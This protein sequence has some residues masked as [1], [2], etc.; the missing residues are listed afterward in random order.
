MVWVVLD[1]C[2]LIDFMGLCISFV[3]MVEIYLV[4]SS[5]LVREVLKVLLVRDYQIFGYVGLV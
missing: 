3:E 5:C 1:F 4:C 2:F